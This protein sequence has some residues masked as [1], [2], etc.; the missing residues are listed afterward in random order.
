MFRVFFAFVVQWEVEQVM[1][2][3]IRTEDNSEKQWSPYRQW[4][5]HK[6]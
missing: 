4:R 1:N 5:T 3:L 6:I 2:R